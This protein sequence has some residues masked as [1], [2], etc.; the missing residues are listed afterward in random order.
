MD[1]ISTEKFTEFR[2]RAITNAF[3][4]ILAPNQDTLNEWQS[5]PEYR[6]RSHAL[7]IPASRTACVREAAAR[8]IWAI[9]GFGRVP[10]DFETWAPRVFDR[11][12]VRDHMDEVRRGW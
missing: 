3:K 6:R 11:P 7:T 5:L 2:N 12:E 4:D 10:D 8:V 1:G 9:N